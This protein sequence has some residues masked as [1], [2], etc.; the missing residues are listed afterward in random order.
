MSDTVRSGLLLVFAL[1][2]VFLNGFFVAAEF[3]LVKVRATR[4]D[5]LAAKG[6]FGA[7]KAKAAVHHLDAYLSATQ[8]GITLASL[9]L[10]YI[11][12]PAFAELITPLFGGLSEKLR[13]GIA[14]GIAFTLIT[15]LH[16]VV[17]ELAPKSLAIQKSEKVTLA[18]IYPLD[19]F[20]RV[21]KW[22]IVLM[23]GAATLVL[24]PWGIAPA[25]EHGAE[26]HSE[27]EIRLI[28]NQSADSGE[29][30]P[31]EVTLVDRVFN[32]ARQTAKEVMIPR[33]DVLFLSTANG[34]DANIRIVEESGYTRFPLIEGG[35]PDTIVGMVHAKD[36]LSVA[37][38]PSPEPEADRLRRLARPVLRVPETKPIDDMLRDFQKSRQHMAIIVDE[39]GGTSGIVTMEDIVEEIVGDINDEFDRAAPELEPLGEDC[40][41]VDARMPLSKLE[42]AL[43]VSAPESSE[44][45][46]TLGGWVLAQRSNTPLR[47]G[48]E[49]E[50][51]T[52]TITVTEMSGR[53]VRKVTVCVPEP[54][55]A[56]ALAE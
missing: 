9:G 46:D 8:L 37:R 32:F 19:A 21:F 44:D 47:P 30:R 48:D 26:A 11:G 5:E 53:R 31:S 34:F 20:Y 52:A 22:L 1:F 23:N 10:G 18:I 38:Q 16:I 49:F 12:E 56:V 3:A 4:I 29:I 6:T 25:S 51:G 43:N 7:K 40:Y 45:I 24:K 33:P 41:S 39:Y 54:T 17:G 50:Y 15:I 55:G 36:L 35:S 42:R 2:L 13:H 14:F 28:L 27:D